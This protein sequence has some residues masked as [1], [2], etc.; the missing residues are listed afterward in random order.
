[1]TDYVRSFSGWS[2]GAVL[3]NMK[4]YAAGESNNQGAGGGGVTNQLLVARAAWFVGK[5]HPYSHSIQI[6]PSTL[7]GGIVDILEMIQSPSISIGRS[8]NASN[9]DLTADDWQTT[10]SI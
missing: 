10:T 1:M 5:V 9:T 6:V 8:W 7:T 2:F 3:E 4:G